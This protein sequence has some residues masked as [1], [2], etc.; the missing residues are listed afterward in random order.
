MSQW[1]RDF[2]IS[3]FRYLYIYDLGILEL[4][5]FFHL[6]LKYNRNAKWD[7]LARIKH[8][9]IYVERILV[10]YQLVVRTISTRI[11]YKIRECLSIRKRIRYARSQVTANI[12]SRSPAYVQFSESRSGSDY[13]SRATAISKAIHLECLPVVLIV[14]LPC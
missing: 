3:N 2:V 8:K 11:L 14:I 6:A 10:L 12:V 13:S 9:V 5:L 4:A 1:N 7:E